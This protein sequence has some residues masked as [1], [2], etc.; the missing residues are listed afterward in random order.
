MKSNQ[1]NITF[2]GCKTTTLEC[3]QGVLDDGYKIDSLVSLSPEQGEQNQVSG[4]C[5]LEDFAKKHSIKL[6]I[7]NHYSLK[8]KEDQDLLKQCELDILLVI[9]WQR[10]LPEWLLKEA[11][12]G[13]LGMH[14]SPEPL[15]RGRGRSPLNWSLLQGKKSFLTHLFKYDS[16][17]DSGEIV[18]FQKFEINLWDD[19]NSLHFKNRISMNKLLRKHLNNI[20]KNKFI[21]REQPKD[22][23]PTYFEKRTPENGRIIWQDHDMIS[24]YNHIRCQTKP[25]PGAFSYLD[26]SNNKCFFWKAAPFDSHLLY[27][28]SRPGE[29]VEVFHDKSFLVSLW[30]GSIRI[31]EYEMNENPQVGL[32]F[33]D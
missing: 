11:S 3:M 21:T 23:K 10:L 29:I 33:V 22:I 32:K 24:L 12:I 15:P 28:N 1:K 2:F 27:E 31:I 19:C 25:F 7:P 4:Y 17:I 20:L 9:G 8:S 14:G 16:G 30:D 13:A 26:N 18:D 5:N 6:I